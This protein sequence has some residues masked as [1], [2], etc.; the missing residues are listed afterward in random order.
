M[1]AD[2]FELDDASIAHDEIRAI[3]PGGNFLISGLTCERFRQ[4]PYT[5]P[6]WP[7]MTLDQWQAK[8]AVTAD[9]TLRKHVLQMLDGLQPAGGP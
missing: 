4:M 5:S 3:G 1:F 9:E 6:I 7:A 8:G 2:G